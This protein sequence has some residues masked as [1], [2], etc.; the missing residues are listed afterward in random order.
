MFGI[1]DWQIKML[2]IFP[3]NAESNSQS[4]SKLYVQTVYRHRCNHS[5]A[6]IE[7]DCHFCETYLENRFQLPEDKNITIIAIQPSN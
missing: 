1:L 2:C 4:T 6:I 7:K 5:G 3:I